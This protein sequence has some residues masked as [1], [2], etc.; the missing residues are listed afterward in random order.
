MVV[1]DL[2]ST[3]V[4][5]PK[6][7]LIATIQATQAALGLR[8]V[9]DEEAWELWRCFND[10]RFQALTGWSGTG[11]EWY[12]H[13]YQLEDHE[14]RLAQSEPFEGVVPYVRSLQASGRHVA[15][16]TN[17]KSASAKAQIELLGLDGIFCLALAGPPKKPQKPDPFG[18][19]LVMDHFHCTPSNTVMYGDSHGDSGMAKAAGNVPFFLFQEEDNG[20][21]TAPLQAEA[22]FND[23][24]PLHQ[25]FREV[26]GTN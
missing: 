25:M 20:C 17:T 4:K 1:F 19:Q 9:T 2:E 23:W 10:A 7:H 6:A 26:S 16:V 12:V 21:Q 5:P 22:V 11:N 24:V 13:F 8:T 3:M 14:E 18:L 15:V